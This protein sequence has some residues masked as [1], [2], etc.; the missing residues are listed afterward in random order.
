MPRILKIGPEDALVRVD[1]IE[2][3]GPKGGLPVRGAIGIIPVILALSAC[4]AP[5]QVV[6]VVDTHPPHHVGFVTEY[7]DFDVPNATFLTAEMVRSWDSSHLAPT[8]PFSVEWLRDEYL[9]NH[10]DGGQWLWNVHGVEG[11]PE[12]QTFPEL[13]HLQVALELP[14]GED[15]RIDSY[16]GARDA[17]GRSTGLIEWLRE[18]G[19]KR[20]FLVGLAFDFCV[21]W[22]AVDLADAGFDVYL[23]VDGTRSVGIVTDDG[24]DTNRVMLERLI[25]AGVHLITSDQIV[26]GS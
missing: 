17:L 19:I 25:R 23:V 11:T 10:R 21:G 26:G 24:Y 20:V 4:F 14:K 8:A 6:K 16:S 22:T 5:E 1:D 9:P 2:A 12:T 7:T 3:F 15:P 13:A 18:R